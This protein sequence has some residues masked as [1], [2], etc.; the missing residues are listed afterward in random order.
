M[1]G[2]AARGARALAYGLVV[3]AL[4]ATAGMA[5]YE[6]GA[7]SRP[8]D[9]DIAAG[10]SGAVQHAVQQAVA[11]KAA[12]DRALRRRYFSRAIRFEHTRDLATIE[13]RLIDQ[14]VADGRQTA[15]AYRRGKAAG[16]KV[17]AAAGKTAKP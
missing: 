11:A 16:A 14:Q 15:L 6:L 10:R 12:S 17:P 5:G 13:Q 7:R 4:T 1:A 2:T 9:A 3:V 8:S